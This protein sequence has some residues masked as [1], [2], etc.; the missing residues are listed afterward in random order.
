M[1]QSDWKFMGSIPD[2]TEWQEMEN[3]W[4]EKGTKAVTGRS[5]S[6]IN[7]YSNELRLPRNSNRILENFS[8]TIQTS[9]NGPRSNRNFAI[10]SEEARA[11]VA[12]ISVHTCTAML[13]FLET[14]YQ[15]T[16]LEQIWDGEG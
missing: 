7:F 6:F 9:E 2:G 5:K 10:N 1:S 12:P 8:C 16:L 11:N 13:V 4:M 3:E 14:L 15:K